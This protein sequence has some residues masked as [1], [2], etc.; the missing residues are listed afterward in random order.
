MNQ[1]RLLG[2]IPLLFGVWLFGGLAPYG[3]HVGEDGDLLYQMFATYEGKMPYVDFST[4]YTPGYFYWHA[5]LFHVFGVDALV[6]RISVAVANVLTLYLLYAL[7]ARMV[8]PGLA[9]L[10]PLVFIGSLLAFPGDFVTFN[11]PY[12]AWYNIALWLASLAATL[13]YIERGRSWQLAIAGVL[14][15]ISFAIK[16]NIGL[17][18]IAALSFFI[19]WWHAPARDAGVLTRCGWWLLALA[20]AAGIAGVFWSRLYVREFKLFPLPLLALA[21]I[22]VACARRAPGRPGF[23]Q[24]AVLLLGGF[25]ITTLPWLTY[26]LV[27][28]GPEV[29]ER[30]VL[31]IGSSYELF[32]FIPHRLLGGP[33]DGGVFLMALLL[34]GVP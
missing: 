4:G 6:T 27:R 8:S 23:L 29:F 24:A 32:F 19:V 33:W 17:F 16:P 10:T 2:L 20:T 3:V 21:G 13:S 14:A 34:V 22:L 30:D 26:F 5:F 9:L 15:G 12:P 18:N 28:L 7:S 25:A 11:V 1:R 31:L